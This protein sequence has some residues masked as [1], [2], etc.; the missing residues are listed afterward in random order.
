MKYLITI[1]HL[2]KD[3]GA[4][5]PYDATGPDVV[6]LQHERW[7]NA[8]QVNGA[9]AASMCTDLDIIFAGPRGHFKTVAPER[10]HE[11]GESFSLG[12][13]VKL[14]NDLGRVLIEFHNNSGQRDMA[15][16]AEIIVWRKPS[17]SA[18]IGEA[19][20][21]RLVSG[22]IKNRGVK[23]CVELARDLAILKGTR[24]PALILEGGF[25]SDRSD[26][27]GLDVDLD[28]FNETY[29]ARIIQGLVDY[30]RRGGNHA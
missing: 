27:T 12:D 11:V 29:G 1:G 3:A 8:Q 15:R 26:M 19:L 7:I 9:L 21:A 10:I 13:R 30:E 20:M 2:G 18:T 4:V 6:A 23:D 17:E 14:A 5:S 16:G 22:G 28:G 24:L 25:M